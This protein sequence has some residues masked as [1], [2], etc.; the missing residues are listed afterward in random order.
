MPKN[1]GTAKKTLWWL[2]GL[3]FLVGLYFLTQ[4]FSKSLNPSARAEAQLQRFDITQIKPGTFQWHELN[5]SSWGKIQF[6]LLLYKTHASELRAWE[7]PKIDAAV[8]M[9]DIHWWLSFYPCADFSPTIINGLVDEQQPIRCEDKEYDDSWLEQWRWSIVTGR[10]L[11]SWKMD[12]LPEAKGVI[13]GDY[14]IYG[15]H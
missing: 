6:H 2:T 10:N 3:I 4:L 7:L 9:P 12:D 11:G 8:A 5:T 1:H 14:F 15:K 13:E